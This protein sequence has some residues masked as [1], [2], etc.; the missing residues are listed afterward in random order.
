MNHNKTWYLFPGRAV[1][2]LPVPPQTRT[3][4]TAA[5][6]SSVCGFAKSIGVRFGATVTGIVQELP[7]QLHYPLR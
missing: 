4:G 2:C 1:L 7:A 3:S 5:F 6:G